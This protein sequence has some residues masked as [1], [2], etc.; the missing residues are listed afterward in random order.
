MR[1]WEGACL[2]RTRAD[3]QG[4]ELSAGSFVARFENLNTIRLIFEVECWL[5]RRSGC[6]I[7]VRKSLGVQP[8][9]FSRWNV[10]L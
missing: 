6:L 5:R 3:S 2:A 9:W 4:T 8:D 1:S 7:L 10:E